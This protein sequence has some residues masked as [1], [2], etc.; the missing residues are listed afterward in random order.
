[1]EY[2]IDPGDQ[3]Y[4]PFHRYKFTALAFVVEKATN[5][6]V[7]IVTFAA[8]DPGPGDFTTTSV[9]HPTLNKFTYDIGGGPTTVDINST[10]IITTVRHSNRA[11]ALTISM[12]AINWILTIC[13]VAI[14]LI[15]L[16]RRGGVKD[17][18]ALLPVTVIL[19]IPTIRS[20]Y[21]GPAP[22]G[23]YLG[24]HQNFRGTPPQRVDTPF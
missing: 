9:M 11:R 20:L 21:V 10:T 8:G 19:S 16:R 5:K 2:G 15:V 7:P 3:Y 23:I 1:M 14:A 6:S 17:G 18:V 4:T 22:F 12:F 13:S 24:T